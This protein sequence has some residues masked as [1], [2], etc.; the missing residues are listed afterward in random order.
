MKD[1]QLQFERSKF[2]KAE[3]NCEMDSRN[4]WK[5]LKSNNKNSSPAYH[6]I[7]KDNTVY[8]SPDELLYVWSD[9]YNNLLNES[10]NT[11]DEFNN[12]FK[13]MIENEVLQMEQI[14]QKQYDDTGIFSNSITV[15][16]VAN[17]C[18]GM[19]N[20]KAPGID[21]ISY[22]SIKYG[23]YVLFQKLSELYNAIIAFSY[24]P[25]SMKHSIIIPLYKGKK[26]LEMMLTHIV[27]F[28]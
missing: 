23:G 16:E 10:P 17:V 22:E 8:S 7:S 12:E 3:E 20:H 9:H 18:I 1:K 28:H 15:N 25:A 11:D 2:Q 13:T 5:Y 4:L 14:F 6:A 24:I 26:N 27:E 21:N 19:P